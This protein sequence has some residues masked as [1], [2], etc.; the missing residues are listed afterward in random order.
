MA[1]VNPQDTTTT[2]YDPTHRVTGVF[3]GADVLRA[4]QALEAAGVSRADIDLFH[5]DDGEHALDP[6]GT[7]STVGRWWRT[8]ENWVSDTA[9]FHDVV[10]DALAAGGAIVAIHVGEDEARRHAV[11][12]HLA[13]F[14][15]RD[16][17]YW[18]PLYV[19]QGH[20]DRPR[21]NLM[22]DHTP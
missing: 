11:M 9:T 2:S 13:A 10:A 1:R 6:D 4:V 14:G 17:K 12:Q 15:A 20:E 3:D 5:G 22:R 16:V 8:L 7:G 19:E 21:Q 18:S